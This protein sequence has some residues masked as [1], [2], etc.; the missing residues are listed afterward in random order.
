M[1]W[2]PTVVV[3]RTSCKDGSVFCRSAAPIRP[4]CSERR[5]ETNLLSVFVL[6]YGY[7]RRAA[8]V[9]LR[10]AIVLSFWRT[11]PPERSVETILRSVVVQAYRYGCLA[12]LS[13][14]QGCRLASGVLASPRPFDIRCASRL[15]F[16]SISHVS[17]ATS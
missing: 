9:I 10:S 1:T 2:R 3:P 8:N 6:A 7:G 11:A 14:Q 16:Q 5:T 15:C 4:S 17:H 13:S 12:R